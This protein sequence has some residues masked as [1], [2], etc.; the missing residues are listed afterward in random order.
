[1]KG[2]AYN[3][4]AVNEFVCLNEDH[5]ATEDAGQLAANLHHSLEIC[6]NEV[7]ELVST[8]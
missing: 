5:R 4:Y 8:W 1:M 6:V 7:G 3:V 2:A